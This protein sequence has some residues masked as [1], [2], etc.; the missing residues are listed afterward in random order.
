[1]PRAAKS[2]ARTLFPDPSGKYMKWVGSRVFPDMRSLAM[3]S[4]ISFSCF[5][6]WVRSEASVKLACRDSST[7]TSG[8]TSP[9]R[10]ISQRLSIQNDS[11]H[12]RQYRKT[13]SWLVLSTEPGS[14]LVFV[15]RAPD[16]FDAILH[17]SHAKRT[18]MRLQQ[19]VRLESSAAALAINTGIL[20]GQADVLLL[21]GSLPRRPVQKAARVRPYLSSAYTETWK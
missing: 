16:A 12:R 5:W 14:V 18:G 4:P 9:G 17:I 8:G 19:L 7:V 11:P 3:E 15:K 13:S 20:P 6:T 1:M 10:F 2:N 21:I